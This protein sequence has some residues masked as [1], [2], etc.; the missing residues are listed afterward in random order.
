M[1]R[2]FSQAQFL[3]M[4]RDPSKALATTAPQTVAPP[5]RIP[6]TY[7]TPTK[8]T[9][10]DPDASVLSTPAPRRQP[11]RPLSSALA[12]HQSRGAGGFLAHLLEH[13]DSPAARTTPMH[14]SPARSR[15]AYSL[16][17]LVMTETSQLS[18]HPFSP[19]H[20]CSLLSKGHVSLFYQSFTLQ[21]RPN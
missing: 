1:I 10:V 17:S 12:D 3:A 16:C 14:H 13:G 7:Q 19:G 11:P 21:W 4:S 18:C 15:S 6:H 2:S 9:R 5:V 8:Q 20:A